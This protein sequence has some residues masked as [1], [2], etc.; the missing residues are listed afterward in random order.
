MLQEPASTNV[1]LPR[2]IRIWIVEE[3][4]TPTIAR[5]VDDTVS[6]CGEEDEQVVGARDCPGQ[7][8]TDSHD[9]DGFHRGDWLT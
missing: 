7:T 1:R 5:N 6:A 2:S 3:L 9:R 4:R 8:T